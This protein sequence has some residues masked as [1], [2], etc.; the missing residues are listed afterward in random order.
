MEENQNKI[1]GR[2]F[3]SVDLYDD[4]HIE[5]ILQNMT[6]DQ[7]LFFLVEAVKLAYKNNVYTIGETEVISK[8]IRVLSNNPI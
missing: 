7:S 2:L 3:D 6:K 1:Y 4:N 5:V 8:A